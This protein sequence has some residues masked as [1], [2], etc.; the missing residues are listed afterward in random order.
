MYLLALVWQN[1]FSLI[2]NTVESSI[3]MTTVV[4]DRY[5]WVFISDS[6]KNLNPFLIIMAHM[7]FDLKNISG[8]KIIEINQKLL[9]VA[10]SF[11][12]SFSP[13]ECQT[14]SFEKMNTLL[15]TILYHQKSFETN[16]LA[17]AHAVWLTNRSLRTVFKSKL[18][19]N[20]KKVELGAS[21]FR[22]CYLFAV[23]LIF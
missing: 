14:K 12:R 3:V 22:L 7:I 23:K 17:I 8:V 16:H 4:V 19:L 11:S 15:S 18:V 5:F 9:K 13:D 6:E 2:A 20:L 10:N 21:F 1:F